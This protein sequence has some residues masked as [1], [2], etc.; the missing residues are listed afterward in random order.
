VQPLVDAIGF[1]PRPAALQAA[2]GFV[3]SA[4][5]V[6]ILRVVAYGSDLHFS[7]ALH[8]V[9]ALMM[10]W[11]MR[12]AIRN[13]AVARIGAPGAM[14]VI[15][16][17]MLLGCTVLDVAMLVRITGEAHAF[18]PGAVTRALM[19]TTE[20]GL[21]AAALFLSACDMPPPRRRRQPITA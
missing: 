19:A 5:T 15:L 4:L 20:D 9:G 18:L 17:W 8:L 12:W 3:A 16:R 7:Q 21:G 14:H 10:F 2:T 11:W 6:S 13:G 1:D